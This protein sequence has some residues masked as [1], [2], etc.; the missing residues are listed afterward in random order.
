VATG[1]ATYLTDT[2]ELKV[3][4]FRENVRKET[5]RLRGKAAEVRFTAAVDS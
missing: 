5:I 2:V 4:L 1:R 3:E